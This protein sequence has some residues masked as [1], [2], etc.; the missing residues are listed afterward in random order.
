MDDAAILALARDLG[1]DRLVAAFPAEV[2]AA[3]RLA[4]AERAAVAAID[5]VTI[6]PWRPAP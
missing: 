6:E 4:D 1:L 5:D 2:I 3:A